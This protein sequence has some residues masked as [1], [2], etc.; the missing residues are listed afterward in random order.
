LRIQLDMFAVELGASILLQ[1]ETE[2]GRVAILADAGEAKH[3]V[4]YRLP[5][6]FNAFSDEP[7]IRIDLMIGTHYDSDHLAGLVAIIND[8]RV[9]IGEAWL[10]PVANDAEPS[11]GRLVEDRNLLALQFATPEGHEILDQY[12]RHKADICDELASAERQGDRF[13]GLERY[14]NIDREFTARRFIEPN[15]ANRVAAFEVNFQAH[16]DDANQTLGVEAD[17]HA[18]EQFTDTTE[19][20]LTENDRFISALG[21]SPEPATI[22]LKQLADEWRDNPSRIPAEAATLALIRKATANDAITASHL[23]KVVEALKRKGVNIRCAIIPDGKPQRFYWDANA[24]RFSSLK[25]S[26]RNTPEILLLGPSEGLVNKLRHKLPIGRYVYMA[27]LHA[28]PIK[29]ITPSNQL[30]YIMALE[31]ANQR[32]LIAGDAGCVDFA[33]GS[34]KAYHPELI[35]ALAPLHVVQV[36]HHGGLNAHF[37]RCLQAAHYPQEHPVSYLLMSHATHDKTRPSDVFTK[38]IANSGRTEH[39]LQILFTSEPQEPRVRDVKQLIAPLAGPRGPAGD[40]QLV[41]DGAW[42]VTRHAIAV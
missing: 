2:N 31:H 8:T 41:F 40:V 13:R 14:T 10:P 4:N 29:A 21:F 19:G 26:S 9:T 36:A 32:I 24:K 15:H 22:E 37:Y 16:I 25:G 12:L 39:E 30:S 28:L 33:P 38:F 11:Q 42:A 34:R 20:F 6:A 5:A 35:N 7:E 27:M 17:S 18:D 3:N 1:F 23:H